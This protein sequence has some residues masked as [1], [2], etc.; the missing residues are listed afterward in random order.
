MTNHTLSPTRA[1][2]YDDNEIVNLT[3]NAH[4]DDILAVRLSRR[5]ALKGGVSVTA[6]ALLGGLGLSACGGNDDPA[7]EAS[8]ALSLGFNAV[9]KNLNDLVTVPEGYQVSI[10]HALGDPLHYGDESWKDDGSE[11]AES[12]NCLLYTSPSP[13]DRTRSRMPSSA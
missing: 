7:P 9:A 2:E 10:L 12:Y 3:A 1:S 6:G 4:M 5:S 11:S 13:R 8:E